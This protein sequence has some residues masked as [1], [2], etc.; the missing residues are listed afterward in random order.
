VAGDRSALTGLLLFLV[1]AAAPTVVFW[2]ALR[3]VPDAWA[4]VEERRRERRTSL[5]PSL[6][7]VVAD[8]RRLRRE[9]RCGPAPTQMRRVALLAAYDDALLDACRVAAVPDPPLADAADRDRAFA[10]L[11]T[12]AALEDAGIAL[13]PPRDGPAAA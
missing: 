7:A 2:I 9:I 4:R 10:R 1:V 11:L 13:D 12:E 6:E 8:L 3:L 5:G